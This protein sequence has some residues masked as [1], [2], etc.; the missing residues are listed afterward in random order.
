MFYGTVQVKLR[1]VG[2][3]GGLMEQHR[4]DEI[5]LVVD[6]EQLVRELAR[7]ILKRYG[8]RVIMA[9]GGEEAVE[10]YR[11]HRGTIALVVLDILMPDVDGVEAFRRIRAIDPSA[12]VVISSGY[13]EAHAADTLMQEGAAAFVQKPYRIAELLKAVRE[14]IEKT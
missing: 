10:L 12:R 9:S 4:G 6:D 13:D 2:I 5:V 7:D 11:Q 14:A 8:Y 3:R 1:R